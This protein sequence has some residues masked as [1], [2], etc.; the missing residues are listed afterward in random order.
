MKQ[1]VQST[2]DIE[3]TPNETERTMTATVTRI[4]KPTLTDAD[5][6]FAHPDATIRG[7]AK[8]YDYVREGLWEY[9]RV[10]PESQDEV[11]L[12]HTQSV[13]HASDTVWTVRIAAAPHYGATASTLRT[14]VWMSPLESDVRCVPVELHHADVLPSLLSDDVIT[15]Q[16]TLLADTVEYIENDEEVAMAWQAPA[17]IRPL[18]EIDRLDARTAG[19]VQVLGLVRD[20]QLLESSG[21]TGPTCRV[22]ILTRMGALSVVHLWDELSCEQQE[23]VRIG[24]TIDVTGLLV[25]DVALE[26]YLDGPLLDRVHLLRLIKDG[27]TTRRPMR[28]GAH[29]APCVVL[30]G[31][32][33]PSDAQPIDARRALGELARLFGNGALHY[34]HLTHD[35]TGCRLPASIP[36]LLHATPNGKIDAA[37]CICLDDE[38]RIARI[39]L[40]RDVDKR[41]HVVFADSR[42]FEHYGIVHAGRG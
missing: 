38:R 36:G 21:M 37:L 41:H 40:L 35:E 16:V 22:E 27:L 39:E 32:G 17:P 24:N 31:A 12:N 29:M 23:R 3:D 20:V 10:R 28:T 25:G 18:R 19:H 8:E 30:H 14:P 11:F 2:T 15:M 6:R 1:T 33:F 7:Y 42:Q 34:A 13:G 26:P 4:S 5:A 9:S